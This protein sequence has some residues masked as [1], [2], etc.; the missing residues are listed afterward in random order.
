MFVV[1]ESGVLVGVSVICR[2]RGD[3]L[4]K[5]RVCDIYSHGVCL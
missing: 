2:L 3:V 4:L 5:I 1:T